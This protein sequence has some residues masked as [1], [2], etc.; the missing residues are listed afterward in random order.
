MSDKPRTT[1]KVLVT[2]A[3]HQQANFLT[4]CESAN[5]ETVS[6]PCID[7]L[8]TDAQLHQ[9]DID[10]ADLVLFT[11]RNA[12]DFAHL[13]HPL[14][15]PDKQVYAIGRATARRLQALNQALIHPPAEPYNSEAFIDW[16]ETH[17][18]SI[19]KNAIT[20]KSVSEKNMTTTG[21]R[22][23]SESSGDSLTVLQIK[24]VG[25][26]NAITK[27]FASGNNQ[28]NSV[29]VYKRVMPV[30]SDA[31]R[32]RVF[33]EEKPN[34]VSITSDEVLRNLVNIAGPEFADALH[35]MPLVV[36]SERCKALATRL[37][38][39]HS[40]V[41]ANPPGDQGQLNAIQQNLA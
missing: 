24:G 1:L 26:R 19:P 40:A 10:A 36:N 13:L 2:R 17:Q 25:G 30:V 23:T 39:S 15:W 22:S 20:T 12:V 3:K 34:I 6:L 29:D 8:P 28:L 14:P 41:V 33:V 31:E 27:H 9:Q 38:F 37:G 7:I 35:D 21:E 32:H 4:L 18:G 16:F 11:S 5:I